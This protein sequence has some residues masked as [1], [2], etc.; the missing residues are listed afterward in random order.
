MVV[1]VFFLFFFQDK[2]PPRRSLD[3]PLPSTL[4]LIREFLCPYPAPLLL[5]SLFIAIIAINSLQALFGGG[6][7]PAASKHRSHSKSH[8]ESHKKKQKVSSAHGDSGASG[9][10]DTGHSSKKREKSSWIGRSLRLTYHQALPSTVLGCGS[11]R[12]YTGGF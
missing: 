9:S 1:F 4:K 8:N 10:G 3:A 5:Y 2:P 11:V 7:K 6:S 12:L